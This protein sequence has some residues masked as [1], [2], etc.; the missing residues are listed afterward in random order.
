MR[1]KFMVQTFSAPELFESYAHDPEKAFRSFKI[2][3]MGSSGVIGEVAKVDGLSI[4]RLETQY[5]SNKYKVKE[6]G[7]IFYSWHSD[8]VLAYQENYKTLQP[9]K[10]STAKT[11]PDTEPFSNNS[12][13]CFIHTFG[14]PPPGT[15][16]P[17]AEGMD[18]TD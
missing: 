15:F 1:Y 14:S 3:G 16:R 6:T 17:S 18:T 13:G 9:A 4:E 11:F 8:I 10:T 12:K 5:Y 7:D 2:G